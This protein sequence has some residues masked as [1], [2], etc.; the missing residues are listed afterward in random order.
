MLNRLRALQ[1]SPKHLSTD[2][3]RPPNRIGGRRPPHPCYRDDCG[4]ATA[5]APR[6][7]CVWHCDNCGTAIAVAMRWLRL[8]EGYGSMVAVAR[9]WLR[10]WLPL[11]SPV[12]AVALRRLSVAVRWLRL[13]NVHGSAMAVAPH[14]SCGSAMA[15]TLRR[16]QRNDG[17]GLTMAAITQYSN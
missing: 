17:C 16:L 15:V 2:S 4:A 14:I 1:V 3:H 6:R 10:L 11:R 5:V 12:T 8:Y 7:L 9:R 13:Y